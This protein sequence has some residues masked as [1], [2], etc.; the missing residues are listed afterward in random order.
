[1]KALS[2]LLLLPTTSITASAQDPVKVD[3]A[4]YHVLFENG[5]MR[6]LEYRDKPGDKAP[7]HSHPAY[8]TYV[9]GAGKTKIV[10]P[11][12]ET[13]AEDKAGSEFACRPATQHATENVGN[14]PTQ[15]LLVEFQDQTDLC[16]AEEAKAN[17]SLGQEAPAKEEIIKVQD[18]LIAAYIH[19]DAAALDRI[20]ADEYTFINDD[21][22]GVVNKKQ[23]LDSFRTGGDREITSY[24]RQGDQVRLYGDVAVLTYRYQSTETYKGQN[25]GGDFRV[26]RIFVHREGRW[27]MVEGQET[28]VS[29]SQAN[30]ASALADDAL[31]LN[32]LEQHWLDAYREGDADKNRHTRIISDLPSRGGCQVG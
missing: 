29:S 21:A 2:L 19:R 31:M 9:T 8:M 17:T 7:M 14:T 28:R 23:I 16:S 18:A 24:V 12:G 3:P 32:Q 4:H 30:S 20:L 11:N 25:N 5:H 27:Q 1:M 6:V 13:N 15:E 22:G 10:Q 26:T